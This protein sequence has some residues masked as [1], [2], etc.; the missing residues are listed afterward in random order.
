MPNAGDCNLLESSARSQLYFA[1]ACAY[2]PTELLALRTKPTALISTS[3]A[4]LN[5]ASQEAVCA[6]AASHVS[7]PQ[8]RELEG[9]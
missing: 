5:R 6:I 1:D 2:T 4:R 8:H 3:G 7:S 9:F